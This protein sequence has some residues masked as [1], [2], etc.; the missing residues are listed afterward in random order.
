MKRGHQWIHFDAQFPLKFGHDLQQR[1]G[2]A[3]ELLFV[4]FLC[5]CKRGYPQGQIHYRTEDELRVLVDADFAFADDNGNKWT[6][7]QF[8][9]WCG[10]RRV[11][12]T[13]I[14]NGRVYVTASRWQAWED[15][16]NVSERSRKASER[17]RNV[18]EDV[19]N[20]YLPSRNRRSEAQSVR[21][22]HRQRLEVGDKRLEVGG[23]RGE[24]GERGN[25]PTP[26]P[27]ENLLIQIE[28]IKTKQPDNQSNNNG[29]DP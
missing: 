19:P 7:E 22:F 3:G 14:R 1:F 23:V 18:S 8:W 29:T 15:A 28:D 12:R 2:P 16:H 24:R 27:T 25:P 5:A 9:K 20:V 21:D 26:P 17:S 11:T 10:H 4:L 13:R 6:L